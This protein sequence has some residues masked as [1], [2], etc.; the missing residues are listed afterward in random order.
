VAIKRKAGAYRDEDFRTLYALYGGS[1]AKR[2]PTLQPRDSRRMSVNLT[3]FLSGDLQI[4]PASPPRRSPQ[5]DHPSRLSPSRQPVP[6][7]LAPPL[8]VAAALSKQNERW[9]LRV[10][11]VPS[12]AFEALTLPLPR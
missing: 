10:R 12:L 11:A 5:M 1:I 6:E 7:A 4:P 2:F 3:I 9:F 8:D